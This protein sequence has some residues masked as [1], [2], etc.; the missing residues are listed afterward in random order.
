MGVSSE[1]DIHSRDS[2][3]IFDLFFSYLSCR[4]HSCHSSYLLTFSDCLVVCDAYG[5]YLTFLHAHI[6]TF[7]L[8]GILGDVMEMVDDDLSH[9]MRPS[10]SSVKPCIWV[11]EL[12]GYVPPGRRELALGIILMV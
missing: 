10:S 1:V 11:L 7:F 9:H 12:H 3:V 8:Y 6:L 5:S 4:C 2:Y